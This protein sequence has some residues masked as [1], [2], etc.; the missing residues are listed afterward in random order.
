MGQ[1]EI[2]QRNGANVIIVVHAVAF[3]VRCGFPGFGIGF[4]PCVGF[5]VIAAL[6]H[7]VLGEGILPVKEHGKRTLYLVQRPRALMERGENRDQHI[8]VVLNVVKI[9]MI[10]VISAM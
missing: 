8:G 7:H 9:I 10:F 5:N 6:R 2:I 1:V 3:T 4:R